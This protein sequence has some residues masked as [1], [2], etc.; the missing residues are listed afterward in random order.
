M[1]CLK[2][3]KDVRDGARFCTHCGAQM[4]GM[5]SGRPVDDNLCA[6][7]VRAGLMNW[8]LMPGQIAAKIG[9]DDF[10]SSVKGIVIQ[11]GVR[12]LITVDGTS[13]GELG[14]G[15]YEFASLSDP[16]TLGR[17]KRFVADLF[18]S[19]SSAMNKDSFISIILVRDDCF[20]LSYTL[21]GLHASDVT[22]SATL[23]LS[24]SIADIGHFAKAMMLDSK[25]LMAADLSSALL[26]EVETVLRTFVKDRTY[27]MLLD[28][29][30]M[31]QAL[32]SDL[33][34]RIITDRPFLSGL[35][36]RSFIV[37]NE[38]F[39][40]L[41]RLDEELVVSEA[42]LE[43]IR[44]RNE[45]MNRL[46]SEDLERQLRQASSE[47]DY[48]ALMRKVDER[49]ALSDDE[50]HAFA[51]LLDSQRRLREARTADEEEAALDGIR[52]SRL[53]RDSE[54]EALVQSLHN[55]NVL[56]AASD[57]QLLARIMLEGEEE[58]KT[59]RHKAE[60]E[61]RKSEANFDL[62]RR[63]ESIEAD[64]E[65]YAAQ[66]DA[67]RQAQ[68][69]RIER[70]KAQHEMELEKERN[71]ASLEQDRLKI[72]SG[73]T[74]EQ[75]MAANPDI[76]AAAA[77]ALAKKFSAQ[78]AEDKVRL[79]QEQ[80]DELK[81]FMEKQMDLIRDLVSNERA[82]RNSEVERVRNDSQAELERHARVIQ[83]TV[84]AVGG[85]GA[86]RT[87]PSCG[88]LNPSGSTFC[89]DCGRRL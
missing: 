80:K 27:R 8:D 59:L 44:R 81:D 55:K 51:L 48:E 33:A 36:V 21:D 62:E 76:T 34:A 16:S 13:L 49:R 54:Y 20:K 65:E 11:P 1:K 87:C 26:S 17:F 43:Q 42:G 64:K 7:T 58:L 61:R 38:P 75:I 2:C 46:N 24:C 30:V 31:C 3:G 41:R 23:S 52:R 63:K 83:T 19:R 47:A 45:F 84:N 78:A 69:I 50:R 6:V 25:S 74:S 56:Q 40:E 86:N 9:Q 29:E 85:V 15:S 70:E 73:M 39:S 35:S 77:E 12:S 57:E 10:P 28:E 18:K 4:G 14:P 22:V 72:Y 67:L 79:V 60:L 5:D 66:L 71:K 32:S 37:S 88:A 82:R 89:Q 53:L 68:G